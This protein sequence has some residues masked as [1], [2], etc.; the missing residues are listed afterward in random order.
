M[1]EA[2]RTERPRQRRGIVSALA[3]PLIALVRLYQFT[4]GPVM[5]GHC[6]FVPTCSEYS[7]EALRAH[8][9]FRG[10]WLTVRRL[11]RCHPFGGSGIDPV[12]PLKGT[13]DEHGL[14]DR[15]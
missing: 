1:G 11:L 3:L 13:T 2:G 5:G 7:I 14:D 6:R 10:S 4:L 12:P 15:Y 9:A 8:G